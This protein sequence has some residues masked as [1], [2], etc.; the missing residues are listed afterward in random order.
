MCY[1]ALE[2]FSEEAVPSF[3]KREETC[4]SLSV[5]CGGIGGREA[6]EGASKKMSLLRCPL[7]DRQIREKT[8]F[9]LRFERLN[10]LLSRRL[11]EIQ[12]QRGFDREQLNLV[13]RRCANNPINVQNKGDR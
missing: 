5:V 10:H 8:C 1:E 3:Q 7:L 2:T 9:E 12:Q 4:G 13:C 6:E 11:T